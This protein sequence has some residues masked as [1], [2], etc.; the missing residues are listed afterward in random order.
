MAELRRVGGTLES[1][2]RVA[3]RRILLPAEAEL[4][5]TL[6]LTEAEYFYF[7]DL[8]E[9]QI[10][11]RAKGYEHIPDIQNGPAFATFLTTQAGQIFLNIVIGIAVG[12]IASLMAPKPRQPKTPPSLTTAGQTGN[13]RFAPQTGFNSFQDL[14]ELGELIPLVF[15]RREDGHGGVRINTKLLWSQMR[16]NWSG[17]QLRGLFLL[18][19]GDLETPPDFAGYAIGDTTLANYINAKIA[20]YNKLAGGRILDTDRYSEGSLADDPGDFADVFSVYWDREGKPIPHV[21]SGTRTPGTQRQFGA[22]SPMANAMRFMVPYELVLKGKDLEQSN[23]DDIDK[24][25]RKIETAFPRYSAITYAYGLPTGNDSSRT[26]YANTK[27]EVFSGI[28]GWQVKY[29][30]SDQ[31]PAE[32]EHFD[33]E[34]NPWGMEDVK[35]SVD[36]DRINGDNNLALG[37]SYLIGSALAICK[38]INYGSARKIWIPDTG[39]KVEA[40]FD[41]TDTGLINANGQDAIEQ[42]HHPYE[43]PVIQRAA[44]GTISNNT[45]CQVTEIG[46]KSIVWR[47]ITGFLNVNSH[48]GHITYDQPGTVKDYEDDN[49]NIQLGQMS[50][51]IKRYSFFRLQGRIAGAHPVEEWKYIDGDI[52]FAVRGNAPQPQYNFIRINHSDAYQY[53][54]RFMPYP[55]NLIQRKLRDNAITK[56]RLFQK[57]SLSKV[58]NTSDIFDVYYSGN[59]FVLTG[60][61]ASNPEWYLGELPEMN[62]E[63]SGV[64]ALNVYDN[65][66]GVPVSKGWQLLEERPWKTYNFDEDFE[67]VNGVKFRMWG[68]DPNRVTFYWGRER[69]GSITKEIPRNIDREEWV[70][71]KDGYQYRIGSINYEEDYDWIPEN[72]SIKKFEWESSDASTEYEVTPTTVTGIGTGCKFKVRLYQNVPYTVTWEISEIGENYRSGD[73]VKFTVPTKSHEI[74]VVVVTDSGALVTDDPW[75]V[76]RNLNPYDAISDFVR[77]DAEQSSHLNQPEH[78]I[79]YVNEQ[80]KSADINYTGLAYAGLRLNSS[81]EWTSFSQFSAYLMRGIKMERLTNGVNEATNLFP[82]IAYALLTD[83]EIGAG[84]LIGTQSVDKD[85]MTIAAKFCEANGFYW[86]G[87][88]TEG[89]NLRDFIFEMAGYC[90]LDFTILGG[91]FSLMPA[92]PYDDN[93]V[94]NKAASFSDPDGTSNLK[95]KALFTDGNIKNLKVSFLSAE[96]RQIFQARALYRRETANGFPERKVLD[97]RLA[98]AQHNTDYMGGSEKDPKETFDLTDFCTSETHAETFLKYALRVRQLIDHGVTFETTPQAAMFLAPGEYFRLYSESTH[99]SRF[100]NGSISSDG[101]VQS[102]GEDTLTDAEIYYWRPGVDPVTDKVMDEVAEA[103]LTVENGKT[104]DANLFNSVFTV[105]KT[106]KS[107]RVYKV[108]SLS[109]GEEGLIEIAGSHVPL[110]ESGSLAILEWPA[111]DFT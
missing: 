78:E 12:Y 89:Q 21:F 84:D 27:G 49:G 54:F 43:L 50:K 60:N 107:D 108:E 79:V 75:P 102:I 106:N 76:G 105:K 32:Q 20:L 13:R 33:D 56:I 94:I 9:S 10:G 87:V 73:K 109:Y 95:I 48:P 14:A 17:Q 63:N 68:D 19:K 58:E 29:V 69:V 16:S 81:K 28:K 40:I 25:R 110:T 41:I 31:N 26:V 92:V 30:I 99:T 57:E 77:Y 100:E 97:L 42:A 61:A 96:E 82:E 88:I 51:Y 44:V 15:T 38:S 90:F 5:Q 101:T 36:A 59:L 11:K 80:H 6:G 8:T 55:G 91:K 2:R 64:L 3:G 65:N 18:S 24:K 66:N 71:E 72:A 39:T 45:K 46:L 93:F 62:S 98:N 53:E 85:R 35:S 37:D 111:S 83:P 104:T 70:I 4:C 86:D 22:F 34:F 74:E 47:Q 1:H 23:K 52:P 103:K 67:P 7:L